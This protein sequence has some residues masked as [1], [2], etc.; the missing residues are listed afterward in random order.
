MI[1]NEF[2]KIEIEIITKKNIYGQ[3]INYYNHK[4]K[5]ILMVIMKKL[6]EIIVIKA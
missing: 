6:K 5:F 3:F 4:F 2:L 1:V